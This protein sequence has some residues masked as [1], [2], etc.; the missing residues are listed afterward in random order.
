MHSSNLLPDVSK[1]KRITLEP[2]KKLNLLLQHEGNLIEFLKWVKSSVTTD[3]YNHLYPQS[4]QPDVMYGQSKIPKPLVNGFPEWSILWVIYTGTYKNGQNILFLCSNRF[5]LTIM[6][7]RARLI[8][9]KIILNKVLIFLWLLLMWIPFSQ[10]CHLTKLL[11]YVLTNY[12]N[13][14]KRLQGST[15][16]KF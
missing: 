10:T 2:E 1:F 14:V 11:K 7:L 5:L 15:D 12:L 6:Q 16:K 4:S 9:P 3:L 8:S 13:L